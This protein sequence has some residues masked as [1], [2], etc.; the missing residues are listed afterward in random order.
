MAGN[1]PKLQL[2]PLECRS[3]AEHGIEADIVALGI[4]IGE[5]VADIGICPLA[6][7]DFN[8]MKANTKW[9]EY[10]SAG[11]AVVAQRQ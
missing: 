10:S 1:D 6:P 8:L 11:V 7:I 2:R 9:V 5:R 4:E 3:A